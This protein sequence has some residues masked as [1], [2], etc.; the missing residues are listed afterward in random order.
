ML[1]NILIPAYQFLDGI[2]KTLNALENCNSKNFDVTILDDSPDNKIYNYLN[3]VKYS[4]NI[5]LLKGKKS[6]A[7]ENWNSLFGH[8]NGEYYLILHQDEVP[9]SNFIKK[10]TKHLSSKPNI[11]SI[12]TYLNFPNKTKSLLHS[13]TLIRKFY[14]KFPHIIFKINFFGPV[15]SLIIKKNI[16]HHFDSNLNW[17]VDCD[18]YYY[19]IKNFQIKFVEDVYVYSIDN[20]YSITKSLNVKH[21]KKL[22]YNYLKK[23]FSLNYSIFDYLLIIN[24]F[25]IRFFHKIVNK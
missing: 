14:S 15:S 11:L 13:S 4:F 24:W 19:L 5:K 17:L 7:I 16:I 25:L 6:G 22:E 1:L 20:P 21:K 10:I 12:G 23:K 3:K 9:C 18:Y 2:I 8:I